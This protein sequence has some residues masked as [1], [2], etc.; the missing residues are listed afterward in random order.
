MQERASRVIKSDD[1]C[2]RV[3]RVDNV[4]RNFHQR[5]SVKKRTLEE[6]VGAVLSR[7]AGG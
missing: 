3:E 2:S 4:E 7:L 6:S 1:D 5:K